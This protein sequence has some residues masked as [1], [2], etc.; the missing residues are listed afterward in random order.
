MRR[1]LVALMCTGATLFHI[2]AWAQGRDDGGRARL[3]SNNPNYV[4]AERCAALDRRINPKPKAVGSALGVFAE[5]GGFVRNKALDRMSDAERREHSACHEEF[6]RQSDEK[7]R[8]TAAENQTLLDIYAGV[9][10][11]LAQRAA[12]LGQ[13]SV[14]SQAVPSPQRR[15]DPRPLIPGEQ[16]QTFGQLAG[17]PQYAQSCAGQTFGVGSRQ[18]EMCRQWASTAQ[19]PMPQASVQAQ[20]S[21]PGISSY[22]QQQP[23]QAAKP[24]AGA[25]QQTTVA[26]PTTPTTPRLAPPRFEHS[27][28]WRSGTNG[29]ADYIVRVRNTGSANIQCSVS[30]NAQR[31]RTT[32]SYE[33]Y[34]STENFTDHRTTFVYAGNSADVDWRGLIGQPGYNVNCNSVP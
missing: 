23:S 16:T 15:D 27:S 9:Q 33:S 31:Y 3:G 28:Y 22:Y 19:A 5:T 21:A 12:Q 6:I 8:Q 17:S 1:I 10:T 32:S 20:N 29:A 34:G 24:A 26:R 11:G 18:A 25:P 13:Q 30:V 14:Q 4:S 2:S 7:A